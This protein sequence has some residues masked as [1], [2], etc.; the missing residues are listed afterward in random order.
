MKK[1]AILLITLVL[2][3]GTSSLALAGSPITYK[4]TGGGHFISDA[5]TNIGDLVYLSMVGM[6]KDGVVKGGGSYRDP[7]IGLEAKLNFSETLILSDHYVCFDG[8]ADVYLYDTFSG[9]ETLR[10]CATDEG[11]YDGIADRIGVVIGGT[12]YHYTHM[13]YSVDD[14]AGH[15]MIH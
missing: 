10:V 13:G 2:L 1:L 3:L 14:Y 9:N 7:A 4:V 15:I 11:P 12:S 5:G 6:E 8:N